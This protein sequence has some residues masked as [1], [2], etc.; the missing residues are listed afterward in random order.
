M[1]RR[2]FMIV[3]AAFIAL[4]IAYSTAAEAISFRVVGAYNLPGSDGGYRPDAYVVVKFDG[5]T[6]GRTAVV[7]NNCNPTW[8][9]K[10]TIRDFDGGSVRF[11]VYD[12]DVRHDDLLGTVEIHDTS[13]GLRERK[14]IGRRGRLLVKFL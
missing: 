5:R 6:I 11:L 2:A 8:G 13:P 14:L 7:R 10:F 4:L 3:I 12:R 1:E 9:K